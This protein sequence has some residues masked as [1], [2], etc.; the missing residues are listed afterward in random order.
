MMSKA[1]DIKRV[2][3]L[4]KNEGRSLELLDIS[5]RLNLS[6]NRTLEALKELVKSGI[7]KK[8]GKKYKLLTIADIIKMLPSKEDIERYIQEEERKSRE[9]GIV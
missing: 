1:D 4:L 5:K 6:P 7:V 9:L 2:V 3:E 8:R